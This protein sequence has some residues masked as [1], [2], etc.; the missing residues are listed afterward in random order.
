MDWT[1]SGI[2]NYFEYE[3]V[4]TVPP[5]G[6]VGNLK[7]VTGGKIVRKVDAS[8]RQSMSLEVDGTEPTAAAMVRVWHTAVLDGETV[9][10]CLGTFMLD[11][12]NM[13]YGAGR[14]HGSK[15]YQSTLLRLG[16]D[17]RG[18]NRLIGK[19]TN[20]L[21]LAAS[22]VTASGGTFS[23]DPSLDTAKAFAA[24]HV[25]EFG[26]S[27]LDELQR[28]ADALGATIGVDPYGSVTM[29][30]YLLPAQRAWSWMLTT[31]AV[32]EGLQRGDPDIFNI[33]HVDYSPSGSQ[34]HQF[35]SSRLEDGQ[36]WAKGTIGRWAARTYKVTELAANSVQAQ[37]DRYM[38]QAD[39]EHTWSLQAPYI[40]LEVGSR[41]TLVYM[42]G[43][44]GVVHECTIQSIEIDLDTAMTMALVLKEV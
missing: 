1:A 33:V 28:C 36:A 12:S 6:T 17:K 29:T 20:V 9:R 27:A 37:A 16:T 32:M 38:A 31:D 11:G 14:Y 5:F 21:A 44:E 39:T 25:W 15:S 22:I 35:A 19:G 3:L 41:G 8:Y 2:T 10:E 18:N 40:P 34:T 23:A 43:G 4:G 30:P 26:E 7:G 24:D 42:D 13:D